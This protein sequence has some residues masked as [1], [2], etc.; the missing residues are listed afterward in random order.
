[1]TKVFYWSERSTANAISIE[2]F[3]NGGESLSER[4][5][6]QLWKDSDTRIEVRDGKTRQVL[7]EG[8]YSDVCRGI[9]TRI[10]K[11]T[12]TFDTR[13]PKNYFLS[14]EPPIVIGH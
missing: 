9:N 12:R 13:P 2:N 8:T 3:L 5:S 10:I 14:P 11:E 6:I 4:A 7:F 1:M